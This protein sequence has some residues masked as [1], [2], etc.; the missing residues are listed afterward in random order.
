MIALQPPDSA[1]LQGH[2]EEPTSG[3]EPL[4]PSLRAICRRCCRVLWGAVEAAEWGSTGRGGVGGCS[5]VRTGCYP[6]SYPRPRRTPLD[7]FHGGTHDE[8]REGHAR[9][10]RGVVQI[11]P[12]GPGRLIV[13]P[14]SEASLSASRSSGV[15]PSRCTYWH[16]AALEAACSPIGAD[17]T[18][19]L[20]NRGDRRRRVGRHGWMPPATGTHPLCISCPP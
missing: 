10:P 8:H 3:F 11:S 13:R 15:P 6:Q 17:S 19:S 4:T 1:D 12:P 18:A 16:S 5:P 2:H 14:P 9:P 7:D 20:M